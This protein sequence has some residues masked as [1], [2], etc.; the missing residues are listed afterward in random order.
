MNVKKISYFSKKQNSLNSHKICSENEFSEAF[1]SEKDDN[2]DNN[3][4]LDKGTSEVLNTFFQ[5]T[6]TN[7]ISIQ[8]EQ[9]SVKSNP[10][11]LNVSSLKDIKNVNTNINISIIHPSISIINNNI[12][13]I[14]T[15][16]DLIKGNYEDYTFKLSEADNSI[17]MSTPKHEKE[18]NIMFNHYFD[19]SSYSNSNF[20]V[21]KKKNNKSKEKEEIKQFSKHIKNNPMIFLSENFGIFSGFSAYTYKNG[22]KINEDKMG[23]KVNCEIKNKKINCFG[24]YDGQNGNKTSIYLQDNLIKTIL[25]N[26]QFLTNPINTILESYEKIEKN[27]LSNLFQEKQ[28]NP[29]LKTSGSSSLNLLN[30]EDKIY[31]ANL[32]DS[33]GIISSNNSVKINCLSLDHTPLNINEKERIKET[34]GDIFSMKNSNASIRI[35]PGGLSTTRIFGVIE[36]K[37]PKFGGRVNVISSVPDIFSFDYN[38]DIDFIILG[39]SNIYKMFSNKELCLI[40]YESMH[41][42]IKTKKN[43]T[44][45]LKKV[46]RNIMEKCILKGINGNLSC[47]FLPFEK[48]KKLFEEKKE[49]NIRN[50]IIALSLSNQNCENIYENLI[51][52]KLYIYNNN[53]N[54]NINNDQYNI[55]ILNCNVNKRESSMKEKNKIENSSS[56][57]ATPIKEQNKINI[58]N[59]LNHLPVSFTFKKK[60]KKIFCCGCL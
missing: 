41:E 9:I 59:N 29:D 39:S 15:N 40:V 32:G 20:Y 37:L 19:N 3:L 57:N 12:N 49:V 31:I 27:I 1:D 7:N 38:N 23:I 43:Y 42:C 4:N 55:N 36:S 47:I 11:N 58:V 54:N 51:E 26:E 18:S 50:I 24:I 33:R 8:A 28:N 22:E 6:N 35:F 56:K 21:N 2:F 45:Y 16:P 48:N 34:K 52:R 46:V 5:K 17:K 10:K 44:F 14:R 53:N 25:E 30:I 13:S 60:R